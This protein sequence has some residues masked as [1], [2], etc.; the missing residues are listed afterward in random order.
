M[1]GRYNRRPGSNRSAD[2]L[3]PPTAPPGAEAKTV[4]AGQF[5][6]LSAIILSNISTGIDR[7]QIIAGI[8]GLIHIGEVSR[9]LCR[10]QFANCRPGRLHCSRSS[11]P[12]YSHRRRCRCAPASLSNIIP[13]KRT[14]QWSAARSD[15]RNHSCRCCARCNSRRR[16]VPGSCN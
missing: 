6:K 4:G 5:G 15:C 8:K 7:R 13:L 12:E 3:A 14:P 11:N 10:I 1:P 16:P 9:P 2:K